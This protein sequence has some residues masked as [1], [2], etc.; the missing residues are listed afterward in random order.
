MD[1]I[2]TLKI[3]VLWWWGVGAGHA[4]YCWGEGAEFWDL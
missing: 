3:D 2:F 1:T 4:L